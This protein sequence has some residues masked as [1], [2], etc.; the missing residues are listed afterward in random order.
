MRDCAKKLCGCAKN[1]ASARKSGPCRARLRPLPRYKFARLCEKT[2]R[3]RENPAP[4]G[5]KSPPPRSRLEFPRLREKTAGDFANMRERAEI[6]PRSRKNQVPAAL[7]ICAIAPKRWGRAK[8]CAG[9]RKSGSGRVRNLCDSAQKLRGCA[10]N[11]AT[12][13]KS[14]SCRAEIRPRSRGNSGR[15]RNL[16]DCAQKTVRTCGKQRDRAT[17]RFRSRGNPV[18]VALKICAT[19]RQNCANVR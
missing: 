7:G 12:A 17:T 2:A 16:R 15:V 13:R 11:C 5:R 3:A 10:E 6:R 1:C 8:N 9:A 19:V 4:A 14:G 18:P